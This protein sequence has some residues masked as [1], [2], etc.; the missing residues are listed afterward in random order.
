MLFV[1][2]LFVIVLTDGFD[3]IGRT[4]SWSSECYQWLWSYCWCS[5]VYSYGCWQG[6][7]EHLVEWFSW[8]FKKRVFSGI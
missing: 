7:L 1:P 5:S 6:T 3:A 2:M 4:S 8:N